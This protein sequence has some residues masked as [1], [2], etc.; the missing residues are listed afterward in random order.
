MAAGRAVVV[1]DTAETA[2]WPSLDPQ[3]WRERQS[4]GSPPPICVGLDLR[5]EEHSLMV[6]MRRLAADV[7]LRERLAAAGETYWREHHAPER[8]VP[9]FDRIL[10][11]TSTTGPPPR[12]P[13]WP[14][15]L[16]ADGSARAREILNEMGASVDI[17]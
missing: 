16:D 9:L 8:V 15:H 14:A 4:F 12:P 2:D 17:V 1:F 3:T 5:D 6:A 13:G 10:E 7:P 11:E